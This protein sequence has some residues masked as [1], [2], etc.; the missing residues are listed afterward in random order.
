[1]PTFILI[2]VQYVENVVYSFEKGSVGQKH[3]KSDSHYPT[4]NPPTK[5]PIAPTGEMPLYLNAI[6]KAL[7][8]SFAQKRIFWEN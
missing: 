6:S 2:Y 3:F 1:M 5:F 7:N 4:K 8:F